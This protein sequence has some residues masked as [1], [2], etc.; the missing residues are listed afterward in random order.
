MHIQIT[1]TTNL[2]IFEATSEILQVG[3]ILLEIV[4]SATKLYTPIH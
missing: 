2:L 1:N 4:H 3:S